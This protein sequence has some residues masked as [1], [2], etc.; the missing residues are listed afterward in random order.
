SAMKN[1]GGYRAH[2]RFGSISVKDIT[3]ECH[4]SRQTFYYHYQDIYGVFEFQLQRSFDDLERVCIA[5]DD[6]RE[7][8][9][10][11]VRTGYDNRKLITKIQ[12]MKN[13]QAMNQYAIGVIKVSVRHIVEKRMPEHLDLKKADLDVMIEFYSY[14]LFYYL[15]NK[16][17]SAEYDID[18][19]TEQLYHILTGMLIPLKE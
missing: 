15:V 6:S 10:L 7:A 17:S 3:S 4:I 8:L 2:A 5:L 9:R 18:Q 1:K 14:G 13:S 19:I 12:G 16:I 11:I